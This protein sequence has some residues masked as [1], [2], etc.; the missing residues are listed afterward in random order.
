[1]KGANTPEQNM[2]LLVSKTIQFTPTSFLVNFVNA[3]RQLGVKN[4]EFTFNSHM[5]YR[6]LHTL[7]QSLASLSYVYENT[8]LTHIELENETYLADYICGTANSNEKKSAQ[9]I[10]PFY[11]Y[12]ENTVVPAIY[13]II[14]KSI[15]IGLSIINNS[16]AKR[17]AYNKNV[18]ETADNLIK[19]GYKVYLIPHAYFD[20]YDDASIRKHLKAIIDQ[21]GKGYSYRLTEFNLSSDSKINLDQ[22]QTIGFYERVAKI[23]KE[24]GI[25][26]VH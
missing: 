19:K 21:F 2:D 13:T 17:K 26:A 18:K 9:S 12:L 5:P 4:V 14:P 16:N 25:D 1:M 23:A 8:N 10:Q 22:Q 3:V 15:Q 24:L 7:E 11:T 6:G 20:N